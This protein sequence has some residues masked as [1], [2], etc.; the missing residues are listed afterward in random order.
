MSNNPVNKVA[1]F[2]QSIWLDFIRRSLLSSGELQ[3]MIEEDGLRGVTVNPS[4]LEKAISGSHDYD[5]AIRALVLEGKQEADIYERLAVEDVQRAADLF[6]P[7][8]DQT[9]GKHGFV[10]LEV[11]PYLAHD[12]QGTLAEARRFWAELNR[13]NVMIKVPAT[14]EGLPAIRQL[15]AEG[16][17][18]NVTLLFGLSR[19]REVAESYME[20]L[21]D[22]G[23]QGKALDRVAS[24]ASF[25]LSRIDVLVDPM[26]E[27]LIDAD[28]PQKQFA[29]GLHGQ[30]AIASAR[31]AYQIYK[32]I[33]N[34]E[35]FQKLADNGART[36]RLLWA[37]TSTKNPAYSDVKY[38]DSLI[39]PETVN[40]VPLETLNA[41]RDH[42]EPA[43]RLEEE[44]DEA[45]QV[46]DRLPE[47]DIDIDAVTQQ[48][49][50]E[51]VEKFT[52]SYDQLMTTL[53]EKRIATLKEPVDRQLLQLAD[54]EA[55]VQE[56]IAKLEA[57]DFSTRLWRK[58]ASLWKDDPQ[59]QQIIRNALGWLYV[60]EK[61]EENLRGLTE[62]V[63]EV[64]AAGFRHVVHMGMG[65]SSLAPLAF[66]RTFEAGKNGLGL[67]V[68]DTTDP[69]TILS[70]EHQ[71]PL[72]NTLFIVASK[73]GTTAE[74]LAFADYFYQRV[75]EVKGD[76]AGENFVAITDAG[77]PLVELAQ[78]KGYRRTFLNFAD[79]GGRYSA[80]S[81]FGLVPAALMGVNIPELLVRALRMEHASASCVGIQTNPGVVLGAVMGE[82]ALQGRDKVTFLVPEAIATLG[83]WLEQLLAESTGKDSTGLLPVAGEPLADPSKYG[84]DRLFV[85][86]RPNSDVD[87]ALD[88]GILALQKAEQPVVTIR[89]DDRLDLG[90]EFFRWE[91]ATATAGAILGINAFNQPNVQESKD[92][93][94]RLLSVVQEKGQLPEKEPDLV[95]EPLSLYAEDAASTASET[96]A[97]FLAGA[98]PGDY[99]ALMAYLTETS[100]TQQRLEAIRR[101]LRD[102]L[103]LA[104]TLGYGPRFLHSTGQFHKGGPNTGLFL[105]L[106]AQDAQGTPVPGKDYSFG[107]LKRAQ[108]L[109]DLQALR[110]HHR[111]VMRIHLGT[112]LKK[113]LEAL[114]A[115]VETALRKNRG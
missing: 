75:K 99:V 12:T 53:K 16:I 38:V 94:N 58:D 97:Q 101:R 37:S 43:P 22:R 87:G 45:R 20:G 95:E 27:R 32:E 17:N 59:D 31:I 47:L 28:V 30:V 11:S 25:F 54:Y 34:A 84:D 114:E 66:Q 62:F 103:C 5:E 36:Q 109:G 113:G 13:P 80:L 110:K 105:Q 35:R 48:L 41:Y 7:L 49:E 89:M 67:T 8:Y 92:N 112:D 60:A 40:T 65:G 71:V 42:G 26:L 83:M 90:Q 55:M 64:K 111:R 96:L 91:I 108:A 39:G 100:E 10:S 68:L 69:A 14:L 4:I 56:R 88:R 86:L 77:T 46:L 44:V 24:V 18:V 82:L 3:Q 72:V 115:T 70:I 102:G 98:R 50:D 76:R 106:T 78:E 21:E 29:I 79:I 52:A 23:A 63:T 93:T 81:Y 33:F 15:I 57:Q 74:P 51:G 6:R 9:D 1:T 2:G 85:Y 19:Y 73:S 104:T 107:V 61:M